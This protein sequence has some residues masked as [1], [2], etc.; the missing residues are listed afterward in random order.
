[1]SAAGSALMGSAS[2]S[3]SGTGKS[4]TIYQS[5]E[6]A[7]VSTFSGASA[8]TMSESSNA[9]TRRAP[10]LPSSLGIL[11]R[12]GIQQAVSAKNVE[13]RLEW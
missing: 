3:G 9:A 5:R 8:Q 10:V 6:F 7:E 11:I 13:G 1:M 4:R 12:L 2:G